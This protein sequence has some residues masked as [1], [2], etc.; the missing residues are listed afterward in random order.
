MDLCDTTWP[1]VPGPGLDQGV[2]P[3]GSIGDPEWGVGFARCRCAA[4]REP[5]AP[6]NPRGREQQLENPD[7]QGE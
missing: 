3:L 1:G 7:R 2:L 6:R 5:K 4:F